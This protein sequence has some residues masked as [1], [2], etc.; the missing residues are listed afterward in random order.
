MKFNQT[1]D[2]EGNITVDIYHDAYIGHT[3]K[4]RVACR[5]ILIDGDKIL[6]SHEV[7]QGV[8]TLPG[9]G[10]EEGETLAQCCEREVLEETGYIVKA[11]ELIIEVREYDVDTIHESHIFSCDIV[12]RGE[13]HLTQHEVNID[14]TPEWTEIGTALEIFKEKSDKLGMYLREYT[15]ISK[16][17]DK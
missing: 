13:R 10:L 5:G 15:A 12:S 11:T 6:L 1:E 2:A 17:L 7:R 9:G 14:M 8:Y 4:R 16:Y 3:P